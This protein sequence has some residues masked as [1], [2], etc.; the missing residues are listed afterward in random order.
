MLVREISFGPSNPVRRFREVETEWGPAGITPNKRRCGTFLSD[1]SVHRSLSNS[2]HAPPSTKS[3]ATS[4]T[5]RFTSPDPS[6]RV[7]IF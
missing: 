2:H 3:P 4:A 6:A 1:E 5:S 7:V